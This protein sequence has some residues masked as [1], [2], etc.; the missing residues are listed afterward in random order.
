MKPKV[1]IIVAGDGNQRAAAR[2][3]TS[4]AAWLGSDATPWD[5]LLVAQ[6]AAA[7]MPSGSNDERFIGVSVAHADVADAWNAGIERATGDFLLFLTPRDRL[8]NGAVGAL[9]ED[10]VKSDHGAAFGGVEQRGI[11]DEPLTCSMPE[12]EA[13]LRVLLCANAFPPSAAVVARRTLGD[14][15][16]RGNL[17]GS[18]WHD[19]CLRLAMRG[20]TWAPLRRV[21]AV[22][23]LRPEPTTDE[24]R[25]VLVSGLLVC[26][27]AAAESRSESPA[28]LERRLALCALS[29]GACSRVGRDSLARRALQA[30][31]DPAAWLDP[32]L[33]DEAV[34]SAPARGGARDPLAGAVRWWVRSGLLGRAPHAV[35]DQLRLAIAESIGS[36][37]RAPA[38]MV[39]RC[40]AARPIILLGLGRNARRIA[41]VM[42]SRGL[43]VAG[44]DEALRSPP[45]WAGRDGV[46]VRLI[47]SHEP[48]D[49]SATYLMTPLHDEEY[50]SRLPEG[51]N[52]IRWR[53]ALARIASERESWLA[54]AHSLLPDS[55]AL[56]RDRARHQQDTLRTP[57]ERSDLHQSEGRRSPIEV[58][59]AIPS[60]SAEN[61]ARTLPE[62]RARGYRIAL[63]Q[64][65]GNRFEADADVIVAPF[66]SYRGYGA[67]I[68]HLIRK[69][70]PTAAPIVVTGGDD[71]YPEMGRTAAEIAEEFLQRFPDTF[72]VMQPTGDDYANT[73]NVCGSPWIGR[74]FARRVYGGNGPYCEEYFQLYEDQELHDVAQRLGVLWKRPD[75]MHFHRHW[76]RE[77]GAGSP[78][79]DYQQKV[80]S[81]EQESRSIY[82]RRASAGFPGHLPRELP[83]ARA[84]EQA[85]RGRLV[86]LMPAKNEAWIIGLSLTAALMWCDGVIV[87]DHASTDGTRQIIEEVMR[88]HVGRIRVIAGNEPAWNEMRIRQQLLEAAREQR[89]DRVALIDADEIL[90]A[91]LLPAARECFARGCVPGFA[92]RLPMVSPWAGVDRVR[93]DGAFGGSLYAGFAPSCRLEYTVPADGYE[94]HGRVPAGLCDLELSLAPFGGGGVMHMQFASPARLRAKAVWYKMT[95]VLRFGRHTSAAELNK[96]Y[97]WALAEPDATMPMPEVWWASYTQLAERYLNLRAEPWHLAE[98]RRMIAEHGRE[99]FAGIEFHGILD[100]T[101]ASTRSRAA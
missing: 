27:R 97:D 44:R 93:A 17:N 36:E 23:Q 22:D 74:E 99:R 83:K 61:C 50:I 42:A 86:A 16:F 1:S 60:A 75:L 4:I 2:I 12:G 24:A 47:P 85:A 100:G 89:A 37:E 96:T 25:A 62:W 66:D 95:E 40:D 29:M 53:D 14:L 81:R 101:M 18:E 71:M 67:S 91:N 43:Q 38:M 8:I 28:V 15:R 78:I 94:M 20:V 3:I 34:S 63:L 19:M 32:S 55:E 7:Q 77:R 54:R 57:A 11:H 90:T 76:R 88:G 64:D 92:M 72:G 70:I 56:T 39:E 49:R 52:I 41:S 26:E 82:E 69:V 46:N 45:Q 58:W 68:N 10:A 13:D 9:L 79:P 84:S 87:Y 33:L 73:A 51:L 48:W 6:N 35:T 30:G 65:P 31:D 98:I 59:Y 21:V 80:L 5:V